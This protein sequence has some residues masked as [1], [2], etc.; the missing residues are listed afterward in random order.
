MQHSESARK[1]SRFRTIG[2]AAA[3]LILAGAAGLTI[4]GIATASAAE[5]RGVDKSPTQEDPSFVT[6]GHADGTEAASQAEAD[7]LAATTAQEVCIA[8][9]FNN[10]ATNDAEVIEED[11]GTTVRYYGVCANSDEP[12]ITAHSDG[13][14]GEER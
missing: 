1:P 8:L 3:G 13:P 9:N 14:A 7:N 4:T 10:F 2:I 6:W 12:V 5:S 11:G